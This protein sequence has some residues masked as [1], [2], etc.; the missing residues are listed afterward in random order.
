MELSRDENIVDGMMNS[1]RVMRQQ[2]DTDLGGEIL[3]RWQ[4][5]VLGESDCTYRLDW[6]P[7]A[8][9]QPQA[10]GIS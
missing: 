3:R 1:R 8:G 10:S 5:E 9:P 4:L 7:A 2:C 6:L